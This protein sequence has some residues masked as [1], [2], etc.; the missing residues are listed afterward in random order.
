[1]KK[2]NAV[3]LIFGLVAITLCYAQLVSFEHSVTIGSVSLSSLVFAALVVFIIQCVAFIPAYCK[4]T[5]YFYDLIGGISFL[6]MIFMAVLFSKEFNIHGLILLFMV[7]VWALRLSV[8]LFVRMHKDKADS[9][10]NSLKKEPYS[11]LVAWIMQGVWVVITSS[12]M[13]VAVVAPKQVL[14]WDT[15]Y[16]LGFF[17]W[18]LGITIEVVADWQKRAF[19]HTKS[20]THAFITVGLWRY[21]RHPNY[22]GEI[23][24]WCGVAMTA[25]PFLNGWQYLSVLSP[26]FVYLLL[27]QLS[28]IPLLESAADEKWGALSTYQQYK[29][30]TPVLWPFPFKK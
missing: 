16:Y 9:R 3:L 20:K 14:V 21:S 11:F 28:G 6:L 30:R 10:F 8:F 25:L 4:Q 17:V 27:S 5:E 7:G 29:L 12:V 15:M 1:M 13:F 19:R 22:L 26:L 23:I 24:L 18:L 2:L